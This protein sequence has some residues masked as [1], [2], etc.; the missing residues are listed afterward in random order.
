M[1]DPIDSMID[2]DFLQSLWNISIV[3]LKSRWESK[4][5]KEFRIRKLLLML[6]LGEDHIQI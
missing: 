1:D 2:Y 5:K 3:Q 4:K 6:A